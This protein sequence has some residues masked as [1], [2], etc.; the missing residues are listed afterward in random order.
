MSELMLPVSTRLPSS[1]KMSLIEEANQAGLKFGEYVALILAEKGK[2]K[3]VK[4]ESIQKESLEIKSLKKEIE[5]LTGKLA[6]EKKKVAANKK[7]EARFTDLLKSLDSFEWQEFHGMMPKRDFE[8][9][10]EGF[11]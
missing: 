6:S 9:I 7:N 1:L 8:K 11:R 5:S 10:T 2:P 3:L 4:K